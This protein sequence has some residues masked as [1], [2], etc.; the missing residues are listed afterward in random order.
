[1]PAYFYVSAD[2]LVIRGANDIRYAIVKQ[3]AHLFEFKT[4]NGDVLRLVKTN[5]KTYLS[6]FKHQQPVVLNQGQLVRR[7]TIVT[8]G[9]EKYHLYTQVNPTTYKVLK[10]TYNEDGVGV[11]NVYYDNIVNV[12]VYHGASRL[13]GRRVPDSFLKQAVLSD[14]VFRAADKAGVHFR[15]VLAMP[16]SSVSY[17]VEVTVSFDGQLKISTAG[18]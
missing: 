6:S 16:D 8:F 13:F 12:N 1:M 11:D 14:I 9:A 17:Q 3:A 7:D 2:T 18:A 15:A 5:D 10:S 4:Q